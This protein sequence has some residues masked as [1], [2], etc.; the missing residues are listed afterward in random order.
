MDVS[1]AVQLIE[2]PITLVEWS[3][4][5]KLA[6]S[7]KSACGGLRKYAEHLPKCN[8]EMIKTSSYEDR[9]E[10]VL[11]LCGFRRV[12]SRS[13]DF[14]VAFIRRGM[15]TRFVFLLKDFKEKGVD[16]NSIRNL[17]KAGRE[18]CANNVR[19]RWF[20]NKAGL[21][22]ILIHAGRLSGD[23]V[24]GQVDATG[25]HATIVQSITA[26]DV[27]NGSVAEERTWVAI[28]KVKEALSRLSN[29][30]SERRTKANKVC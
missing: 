30:T 25:L 2:I 17:A 10:K 8:Y 12:E 24:K 16:A 21:N 4:G 27:S 9:I 20:Y 19:A 3:S 7:S 11:T 23:A 29:I 18:W 28:G 14:D 22:L 6:G 1:E 15:F 26:I 5:S 13:L